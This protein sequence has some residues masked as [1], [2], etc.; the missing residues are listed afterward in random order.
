MDS[1]RHTFI[2]DEAN[3]ELIRQVAFYENKKKQDIVNEALDEYFKSHYP[4]LYQQV[5][6]S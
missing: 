4:E 1:K 3:V 2:I 6:G 5:K